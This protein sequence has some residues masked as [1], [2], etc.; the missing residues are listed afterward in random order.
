MCNTRADGE[1]GGGSSLR[2]IRTDEIAKMDSY[3]FSIYV[4]AVIATTLKSNYSERNYPD[5]CF[6][7]TS[8][9]RSIRDFLLSPLLVITQTSD[10]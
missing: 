10:K 8:N 9:L 7:V 3:I 2:Y 4:C 6:L 1:G 5:G